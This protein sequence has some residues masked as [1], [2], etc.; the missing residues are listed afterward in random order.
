MTRLFLLPSISFLL[1]F[2]ASSILSAA[3]ET[4]VAA[5]VAAGDVATLRALVREGADVNA[6]EPDGTT[7][8]HRAA[9]R[10]DV[11][12]ARMLIA[13]RARAAAANRFGATSLA[14]A[15]VNGS[16]RMIELLLEAGADPNSALPGGETALMTAARTGRVE[17]LDALLARGAD[18]NARERVRGQT[19]L[20]WAAAEGNAAAVTRLLM[21]GAD[22]H[23][24]AHG[25]AGEAGSKSKR[26][27]ALTPLLFAVRYGRLDAVRALLE[28]GADVNETAPDGTSALSIA[29]LNQHWE[30][31]LMLLERGA[32]PNAAA[33][34]WTPLHL[35]AKARTPELGRFPR[36]ET[37]GRVSSLDLARQLIAHGADV[38]A[39]ATKEIEDGYRHRLTWVGTT[40][41]F[42]AAK[43]VDHQMMRL[44]SEAGADPLLANADNITPLMAAAGVEMFYSGEDD[45]TDEDSL[46]AVMLA[47]RLGGDV[48]AAS[49]RGETALHG[50]AKRG[51]LPLLTLLIERGARL[52]V[53]NDKGWT[54][55]TVALGYE[56]GNPI[57]LFQAER[58]TL[59]AAA[60]LVDTMAA[61]GLA[62]DENADA[63]A[64]LQAYREK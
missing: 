16:A 54:P 17:A 22:L 57:N 53:R 9:E 44:L 46:E 49:R 32:N 60:L 61:R 56:K 21:A 28:A 36:P 37:T 47:L 31:A 23:A 25:P 30:L 48:T 24:R 8:L 13:A 29:C 34:G 63:L 55:L 62:I 41:F 10:D 64:K 3:G 6:P 20:M 27:D 14:L 26:I 7:A 40:P 52:D 2:L 43:G 33:Q 18:V 35:L 12:M 59:A 51:Y 4:R 39:R 15:A 5:A 58:A 19:A 42:V 45:G 38:N 50:A 11:V 1:A